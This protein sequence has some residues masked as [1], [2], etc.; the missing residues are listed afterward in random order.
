MFLEYLPGS[1]PYKNPLEAGDRAR[2]LAKLYWRPFVVVSA[3]D[4]RYHVEVFHPPPGHDDRTQCYYTVVGCRKEI[5][6]PPKEPEG[7]WRAQTMADT[8]EVEVTVK[9]ITEKA[10]LVELENLENKTEKTEEMWIPKSQVKDTD[11]LAEGDEGTM[12]ITAWIAK[13][14]GLVDEDDN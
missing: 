7:A 2:E 6:S 13:Q 10:Y 1:I 5:Y 12:E 3:T 11:C 9:R 8:I 4:N 14:K